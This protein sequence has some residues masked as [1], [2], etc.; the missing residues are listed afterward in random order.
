MC[1]Y[2]R[3]TGPPSLHCPRHWPLDFF[4]GVVREELLPSCLLTS[5]QCPWG[6]QPLSSTLG[7]S[8]PWQTALEDDCVV[9]SS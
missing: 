7:R 3:L 4:P 2:F 1:E 6:L 8:G 9:N 5:G